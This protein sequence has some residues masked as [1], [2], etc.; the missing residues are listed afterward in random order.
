MVAKALNSILQEKAADIQNN[1]KLS[2]T[3]AK[4]FLRYSR[5]IYDS[6]DKF[7]NEFIKPFCDIFIISENVK[8]DVMNVLIQ[9]LELGQKQY[10]GSILE[11]LRYQNLS[12]SIHSK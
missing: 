9:L 11:I 10:Q 5:G 8:K 12:L 6:Q 7:L 4:V 2:K 1:F 3:I